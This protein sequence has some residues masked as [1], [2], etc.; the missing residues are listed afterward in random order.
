LKEQKM[1]RFPKP[2]FTLVELLV[3]MAII[4]ILIGLLLPAVQSVRDAARRATCQSNLRQIG[5]AILNFEST[6]S[7]LPSATYGRPYEYIPNGRRPL[8]DIIAS[9]FS[10]ILPFTEQTAMADLYRWDQDWFALENQPAV[11]G[12]VPIYRCPASP[13]DLI[14][15]GIGSGGVYQPNLTAAT[16][17]YSSVYSWGFPLAIPASPPS[18]D[19]WGMSALSPALESGGFA[20][21]QLTQTTDGTSQT[22]TVVEQADQGRRWIKGRLVDEDPP[23]GRAWGPWSGESCTWLLSYVA[24]GS[25]WN[26]TGLG[27]HNININNS[28]GIYAFH[29][30]GANASLLDGSVHFL[31]EA[32]DP[33]VLY[34]MVTRSR[35]DQYAGPR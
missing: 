23:N 8:G 18:H 10:D 7:Y 14:R 34:S 22:L 6:Y 9:T 20:Q 2:G 31:I 35:G 24:D 21:P 5:I 28:Q 11:N 19:I 12:I 13:A 30:A 25:T 16:G 3:V 33:V 29:S 32:V 17:D 1:Q 15:T 27:P 26:P 4:G